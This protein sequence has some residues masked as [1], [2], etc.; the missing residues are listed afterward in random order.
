MQ[1]DTTKVA[2]R[3]WAQVDKNGT[4]EH[5]YC[6]I[7]MGTL[8][9]AGYGRPRIMGRKTLAHRFAYEQMVEPIPEG[10][11][12][13]HLC[14]NPQCVNPAHLEPVTLHENSRRGLTW[15]HWAMRDRCA[16]GHTY[17]E[18]N[19]RW[20]PGGSR[21]CR[22]CARETSKAWRHANQ[23]DVQ[24]TAQRRVYAP[25][26]RE[27]RRVYAAAYRARKRAAA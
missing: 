21:V 9:H 4:T 15:K 13:D 7:W 2:Q 16:N 8:N 12:I 24:A 17:D 3:F 26:E 23:E 5:P 18:A 11:Q 19:T 14:R 22:S 20:T 1:M 25:E 6:W 27:R 10:L